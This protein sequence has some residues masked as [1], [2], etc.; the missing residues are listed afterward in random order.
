MVTVTEPSVVA[1]VPLFVSGRPGCHWPDFPVVVPVCTPWALPES[2][3]GEVV[4]VEGGRVLGASSLLHPA[5][6]I[7]HNRNRIT[8]LFILKDGIA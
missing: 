4:V 2:V 5:R 3:R 7:P 1:I 6:S 8:V